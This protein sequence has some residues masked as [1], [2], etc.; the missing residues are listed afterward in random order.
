MRAKVLSGVNSSG[1][2]SDLAA[3]KDG[4]VCG[5]ER[6]PLLYYNESIR[7]GNV[8]PNDPNSIHLPL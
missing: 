2:R 1:A 6:R 8:F 7:K 4:C 3:E 5:Y